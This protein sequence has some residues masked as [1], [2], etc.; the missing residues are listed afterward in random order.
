[1]YVVTVFQSGSIANPLGGQSMFGLSLNN[2]GREM[3]F[4]AAN[5]T[6]FG[7]WWRI[8]TAA[9]V[10]L[11]PAHLGFNMLLIFLIGRDVERFYGPVVMLSLIVASAAGGALA[12]M[13]FQP[14]VPVGGAST[15]GYGLF[16]MLISLSRIRQRDLRGPIILLL[17][18]LGYSL[19]YSNVS[20]WGHIG[21]L[22]GGA[23]IA[24]ITSTVGEQGNGGVGASISR[25]T[26]AALAA[27]VI[28][29]FTIWTGLGWHY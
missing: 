2:L 22:A 25:K 26:A 4:N 18:N 5:V 6:L 1:M 28:L 16:A 7:E 14:N 11:D 17:V 19:M 3:L 12:C 24:F 21:G 8:L 10:H 20:L 9:F 23:V 27:T 15:V 29:A 13:Y